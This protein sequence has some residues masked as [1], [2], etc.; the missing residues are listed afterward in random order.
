VSKTEIKQMLE[1]A[2]WA[3]T[4]K[5]TEPWRFSVI[6]NQENKQELINL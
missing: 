3:P 1:A 6:M 2:K 5:L 4:H